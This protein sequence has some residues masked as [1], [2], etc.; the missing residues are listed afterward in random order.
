[1]ARA[2]GSPRIFYGCWLVL[3][4]GL[5]MAIASVPFFHSLGTWALALNGHFMWSHSHLTGAFS[6]SRLFLLLEPVIGHL[7]DRFGPRALILRGLC[8]A[9]VGFA[10]LGL[11]QGLPT[12]YASV[13]TIGLGVGLCGST[14][15][16]VMLS[17]WFMRRRAVAVAACLAVSPV[18]SLA[19]TPLISLSIGAESSWVGW[20][21]TAFMVA[22]AVAL[23]AVV[24]SPR[25]RDTPGE[26]GLQ[27]DRNTEWAHETDQAHLSGHT[28]TQALCSRPFWYITIGSGLASASFTA[29]YINLTSKS[30]DAG[31]LGLLG[32]LATI[33]PLITTGFYLV[34][35]LAGDRFAKHRVMALSALVQ[36]LG[37]LQ[38]IPA[39]NAPVIFLALVP[40]SAGWGGLTLLSLAIMPDRFGIRSLGSILGVQALIVGLM[41]ALGPAF[42][43]GLVLA[44]TESHILFLLPPTLIAAFLF[45]RSAPPK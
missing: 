42:L 13:V 43:F 8:V 14:P 39:Q 20:R 41:T 9:A 44:R 40:S 30:V 4:A 21:F 28:L 23:F 22:G 29:G 11:V 2:S 26:M 17:R 5:V 25:M 15:L 3:L 7:A 18:L 6:V 31:G 12:Y 19:L 35:G 45:L 24:A 37:M 33:V 32:S 38:M 27:P 34:G 10:L 1:M 36:A 16:V